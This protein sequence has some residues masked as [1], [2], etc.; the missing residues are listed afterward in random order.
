M[1][2]KVT[3]FLVIAG[4]LL[5]SL[6]I[7]HRVWYDTVRE[8][9]FDA[10]L[11]LRPQNPPGDGPII[12]D[13]DR[14]T[15]AAIGPWPWPRDQLANLILTIA[16]EKPAAVALD[17]LLDSPDKFS[18]AAMARKLASVTGD[19]HVAELAERVPD[20]DKTLVAA[21]GASRTILGAVLDPTGTDRIKKTA[22]ML[23]RGK[24]DASLFRFFE[25]DGAIS[26]LENMISA[27][28]GLGLLFLPADS[29]GLTRRVPILASAG[30]VPV[31]GL[32]TELQRVSHRVPVFF[33][34]QAPDTLTIGNLKLELPKDGMLRLLPA[35]PRNWHARTISAK[36]LL[37]S[38]QEAKA[39]IKNRVVLVGIS[40]PEVAASLRPTPGDV[41]APTVQLQADAFNQ[42]SSG[43]VPLRYSSIES[44]ERIL[45]AVAGIIGALIGF[46][47]TIR[48]S[49]LVVL[50]FVAILVAA[51]VGCYFA[52]SLLVDPVLPASTTLICFALAALA[53]SAETM[54]REAAI[55]RRFEQHLA[56]AVARRIIAQPG[57]LRL[58]GEVREVTALF[59]DVEGFTAMT[60]R[61]SPRK[62]IA[63]L[64]A[65]FDGVSGIVIEHGGLIDKIVGDAV[66]ALFNAPL[67]L[68][69]HP[70]RALECAIA[71]EAFTSAF[72]KK[73]LALEMQFGR[74]RIGMETGTAIVGD[75]GGN[76]K[77]DYTAHGN[78]VNA[79]A[80]FEAA[81]KVLG[82]SLCIGPGAATQIGR[83]SLRPLGKVVIRGR[84]EAQEVFG[85]W[86]SSYTEECKADFIGALQVAEANPKAAIATLRVLA[87]KYTEDLVLTK[88]CEQFAVLA[89]V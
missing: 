60:E 29:D 20:G 58:A 57:L 42:L 49:G 46:G 76:R 1:R 67:D 3:L 19:P 4:V 54:R 27:A 86:P 63:A 2:S 39:R 44:L 88:L 9:A 78:A 5:A 48:R 40:A 6:L 51:P 72:R 11:S 68:R 30:G 21:I 50:G 79:A 81:N 85:L 52:A 13:I 87:E 64:D 14:E 33:I 89:P 32:A 45:A 38:D 10:I 18:P 71:I 37:D 35:D 61:A 65:Y 84:S 8:Q 70:R 56:P 82:T 24:V 34:S 69:D 28:Q 75:V 41:L 55:R 15:L 17:M 77:L 31:P 23:P 59:T 80:R 12:V 25:T 43:I 73:E 83:G 74:T 36:R 66:H 26:P 22:P 16:A 62:L 7:S 53:K 47:M